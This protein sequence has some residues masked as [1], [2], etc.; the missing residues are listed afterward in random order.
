MSKVC[1]LCGRGYLKGHL[2]S[3]SNKKTLKRS[4]VNLRVVKVA[5]NGT[6]KKMR[7][8][9]NCLSLAKKNEKALLKTQET[10]L[11]SRK[12]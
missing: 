11:Q 5:I 1:Q 6:L 9:A 10:R 4:H 8:C 2:V 12:N 7:I 3:F